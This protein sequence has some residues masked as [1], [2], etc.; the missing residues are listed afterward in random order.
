MSAFSKLS[1]IGPIPIW[2]GVLARGIEGDRLTLAIV[3]LSPGSLVPEHHHANEQL[4][5]VLKG[6]L[7]FRIGTE[8]RT[9][10]VGDLYKIPGDVPHQVI[11]GADGAVVVDV[12]SPVRADWAQLQP[13]IP[14]RPEWP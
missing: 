2:G 3:E 6:S 10:G 1:D 5:V 14:A 9:L 4:G 13:L 7:D 8:R 12:F 11:A